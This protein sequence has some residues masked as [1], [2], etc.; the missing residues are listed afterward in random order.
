[1]ARNDATE[2]PFVYLGTAIGNVIAYDA[3]TGEFGHVTY[4][5]DRRSS[6]VI[7]QLVNNY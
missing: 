6:K 4:L 2:M 7:A 5:L 3:D 1:M